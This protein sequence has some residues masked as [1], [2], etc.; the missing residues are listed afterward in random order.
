MGFLHHS[1]SVGRG[2]ANTSDDTHSRT[3]AA[4]IACI[5]SFSVPGDWTP[6]DRAAYKKIPLYTGAIIIRRYCAGVIRA[7]AISKFAL[8]IK[9]CKNSSGPGKI[10]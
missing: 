6:S 2:T 10:D 5:T 3:T 9:T 1:G 4:R 7:V 8:K